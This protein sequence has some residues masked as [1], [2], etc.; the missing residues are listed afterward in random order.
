MDVIFMDD[1]HGGSLLFRFLFFQ[2]SFDSDG[3][4]FF[5]Q[6]AERSWVNMILICGW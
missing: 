4:G 3:M 2:R 1:F 6:R 5:P